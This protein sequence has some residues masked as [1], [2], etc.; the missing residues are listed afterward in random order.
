LH[1]VVYG[2]VQGVGFRYFALRTAN[3]FGVKGY[4]RNRFDG[5]VEAHAEGEEAALAAFLD[6]MKIGPR[7]GHVS[8]VDINWVEYQGKYTEF[9]IET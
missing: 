5:S 1:I 8:K 3:R 9:R 2:V 4:V 6:D 7:S